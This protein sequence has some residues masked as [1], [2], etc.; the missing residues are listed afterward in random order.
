MKIYR[1]LA[2][3]FKSNDSWEPIIKERVL[4]S[5]NGTAA[6]DSLTAADID[7]LVLTFQEM[8]KIINE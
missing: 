7:K 3:R 1:N 4:G 2:I 8:S 5:L 6:Y